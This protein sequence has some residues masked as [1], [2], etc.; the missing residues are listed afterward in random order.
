MS[1][2]NETQSQQ[3]PQQPQDKNPQATLQ[4]NPLDVGRKTLED[5]VV[6]KAIRKSARTAVGARRL[7]TI[8]VGTKSLPL[9]L[10]DKVYRH[11]PIT[12]QQAYVADAIQATYLELLAN[13]NPERLAAFT[14]KKDVIKA[15]AELTMKCA[16]KL[17]YQSKREVR[18]EPPS[19]DDGG[20]EPVTAACDDISLKKG[21]WDPVLGK[22]Q[23]HSVQRA[24]WVAANAVEND[25]LF[26]NKICSLSSLP[27]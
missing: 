18:L 3:N 12:L 13:G 20:E 10:D 22:Y 19:N 1:E 23:R 26:G 24:D 9:A 16:N 5:P 7:P 15:V 11:E 25:L 6:L 4:N 14:N 8:Q 27:V 17:V 21:D 2:C